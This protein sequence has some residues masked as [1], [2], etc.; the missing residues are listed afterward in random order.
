LA[1]AGPAH[2]A[3]GF[4]RAAAGQRAAEAPAWVVRLV[5]DGLRARVERGEPLVV[6]ELHLRAVANG[7]DP[8][9]LGGVTAVADLIPEDRLLRRDRQRHA[10]IGN[11]GAFRLGN[12][13]TPARLRGCRT[14][15]RA[16]RRD[17][18][19]AKELP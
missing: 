5:D 10:V 8:R 1:L 19:E 6:R 12:E 18:R 13:A 15:K 9:E 2:R 14:E 7:E 11:D 4:R 3:L 17:E 16:R